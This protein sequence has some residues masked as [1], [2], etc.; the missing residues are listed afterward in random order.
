MKK[1]TNLSERSL[2]SAWS[3][4]L[5]QQQEAVAIRDKTTSTNQLAVNSS[6]QIT[7][8]II[9][10]GTPPNRTVD[11]WTID[12]VAAAANTETL[13]TVTESQGG[14]AVTTFTS[15]VITSGKTMRLTQIGIALE[16]TGGTPIIMRA[17]IGI[18][19]NTASTTVSPTASPLVYRAGLS[20]IATAKTISTFSDSFPDG[21]EFA[22]NG[23]TSIGVTYLVPDYVVTTQLVKMSISILAYEY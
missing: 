23:T 19:V 2:G 20:V 15:R 1:R 12:Q 14:A 5:Q 21:Y 9:G 8:L 7:S 4:F 22:G 16:Q 18:R 13:F 6:G 10:N 11:C 17:Y 3:P